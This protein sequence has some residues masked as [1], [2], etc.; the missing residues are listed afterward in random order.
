MN[1]K[2]K[3]ILDKFYT[4]K[5]KNPEV[6]PLYRKEILDV[7]LIDIS[8]T[9][10]SDLCLSIGDGSATETFGNLIRCFSVLYDYMIENGYVKVN[11]FKT[12]EMLSFHVLYKEFAEKS[13]LVIL[14]KEDIEKIIDLIE[15]DTKTDEK[16]LKVLLLRGFFE[17]IP[18]IEYFVDMK[19]E[20]IDYENMAINVTKGVIN[21][22]SKEFFDALK[23]Y[24]ENTQ[25][26]IH[27]DNYKN[28]GS[29][30]LDSS[31]IRFDNY[32]LKYND[33]SFRGKYS[34][35]TN[36]KYRAYMLRNIRKQIKEIIE[37]VKKEYNFKFTIS[38]LTISGFLNYVYNNTNNYRL[39]IETCMKY[40]P[41]ELI[42]LGKMYGMKNAKRL[43]YN[44]YV[45][46]YKSK[47]YQEF[48]LDKTI[49]DEE[50]E[51]Y[52]YVCTN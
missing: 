8:A 52:A 10:L 26:T 5:Y 9:E 13:S 23:R 35:K 39:F 38:D 51:K 19:C 33:N 4:E 41:M 28:Q 43:K 40:R 21:K 25:I 22:F 34:I 46:V 27:Y 45:Y 31:R 6:K 14:Y 30:D 37:I 11:P 7:D 32:L 15:D 24:E 3:E 2:T 49:P 29:R 20:N 50:K 47:W 36:K 44:C 1:E 12:Y 18:Y 42:Y 48:L 16:D 17:G